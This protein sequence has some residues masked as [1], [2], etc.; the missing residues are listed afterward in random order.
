MFNKLPELIDPIYSVNHNKRFT[1]SVNQS[2]LKRLVEAVVD[3]DR[4]VEV[5]LD[6]FYDKALKFPAFIMKLNT[7]L[8]L[9]CQ[10]SLQAFDLPVNTEVKGVFTESLALTEDLPTDV[11]VYELDGEKVS[12]FDWIEEELLLCVPLAP[13]DESSSAPA[14]KAE[15]PEANKKSQGLI[16]DEAQKPN[17]FAALQGL[18][19]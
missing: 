14:Y 5:Q 12:P 15:S 7:S 6:F 1:G 9:Q 4:E 17:P 2:R 13:I 18:K 19:K 10:R 11:E 16:D 8:N 3:A